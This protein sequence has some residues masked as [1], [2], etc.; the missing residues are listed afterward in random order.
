VIRATRD[1]ADI[2]SQ[3]KAAENELADA[4]AAV[5]KRLKPLR[6]QVSIARDLEATLVPPRNVV[7]NHRDALHDI[8]QEA[9]SCRERIGSV[10]KA[11]GQHRKAYER[12]EH[13]EEV[14]ARDHLDRVRLDRDSG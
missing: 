5:D 3:I 13:D 4:N 6:P 1:V 9:Q 14:V 7:Q 10:E 8:E 11:I 12:L 2:G